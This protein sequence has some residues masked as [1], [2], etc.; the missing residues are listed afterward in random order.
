MSR[1]NLVC[2]LYLAAVLKADDKCQWRG[3]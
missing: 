1:D 3:E 2:K